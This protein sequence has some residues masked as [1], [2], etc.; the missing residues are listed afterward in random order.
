MGGRITIRF[1]EELNDFLP[2]ERSNPALSAAAHQGVSRQPDTE[3]ENGAQGRR[4]VTAQSRLGRDV[5]ENQVED[6]A[7]KPG[8]GNPGRKPGSETRVREELL[9]ILAE[10]PL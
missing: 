1:Y 5:L 10:N 8:S 6:A 2:V 9:L 3:A 4:P 7:G